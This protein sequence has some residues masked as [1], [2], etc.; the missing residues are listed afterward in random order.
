M[1]NSYKLSPKLNNLYNTYK[2]TNKQHY[3]NF[4]E[5][6]ILTIYLAFFV[7]KI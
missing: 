7:R 5:L 3:F 1:N 4:C 2:L 6:G